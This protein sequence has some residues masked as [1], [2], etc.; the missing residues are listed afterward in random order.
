M[1]SS[2]AKISKR[3]SAIGFPQQPK[4]GCRAV[5]MILNPGAAPNSRGPNCSNPHRLD[6]R[7]VLVIPNLAADGAIPSINACQVGLLKGM[8]V[9]ARKARGR[10]HTIIVAPYHAPGGPAALEGARRQTGAPP[11][12]STIGRTRIA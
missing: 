2:F 10:N 12:N 6:E 11:K 3:F 8:R 7:P 1:P 9:S 4:K 5:D